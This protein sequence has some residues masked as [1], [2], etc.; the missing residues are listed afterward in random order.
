MWRNYRGAAEAADGGEAEKGNK[1]NGND[2]KEKVH[3]SQEYA[4]DSL[5][6]EG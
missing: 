1:E 6:C 4:H 5:C 2:D 3:L